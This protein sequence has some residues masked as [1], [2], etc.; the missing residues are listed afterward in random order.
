TGPE[1]I[2]P[3][4]LP[5]KFYRFVKTFGAGE[6]AVKRLLYGTSAIGT[7]AIWDAGWGWL[8]EQIDIFRPLVY[9]YDK[10]YPLTANSNAGPRTVY[11]GELKVWDEIFVYSYSMDPLKPGTVNT[12]GP[13]WITHETEPPGTSHNA[14]YIDGSLGTWF[15]GDDDGDGLINGYEVYHFETDPEN[16]DTSG[17]L[18]PDGE[19]EAAWR[20]AGEED[21]ENRDP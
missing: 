9:P 1:A 4:H 15:W 3:V 7:D 12:L 20:L 19:K 10:A 2:Q 11:E 14:Q 5:Q 6:N 17:D 21:L 16:L 13:G 8:G 18:L